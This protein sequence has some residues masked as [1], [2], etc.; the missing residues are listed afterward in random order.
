MINPK[1]QDHR[2]KQDKQAK[3]DREKREKQDAEKLDELYASFEKEFLGESKE[4]ERNAKASQ[5]AEAN[6]PEA[7]KKRNLDDLVASFENGD[8]IINNEPQEV[9]EPRAKRKSKSKLDALVAQFKQGEGDDPKEDEQNES[10][11]ALLLPPGTIEGMVEQTQKQIAAMMQAREEEM[12]QKKMDAAREKQ[13]AKPKPFSSVGPRI[14]APKT[15]VA[16]P[17]IPGFGEFKDS[18]LEKQKIPGKFREPL[19]APPRVPQ[20][21]GNFQSAANEPPFTKAVSLAGM[22]LAGMVEGSVIDHEALPIPAPPPPQPSGLSDDMMAGASRQM[23]EN[24]LKKISG[25]PEQQA[26]AELLERLIADKVKEE[27]QKEEAEKLGGLP[28]LPAISPHL[29]AEVFRGTPEPAIP[30]LNLPI[31]LPA[32]RKTPAEIIAEVEKRMQSVSD[33]S[34]VGLHQATSSVH[35][36]GQAA[37]MSNVPRRKTPAEIVAEAEA[38]LQGI[39]VASFSQVFSPDTQQLSHS[40]QSSGSQEFSLARYAQAERQ[41]DIVNKRPL[42]ELASKWTSKKQKWN[43]WD[44]NDESDEEP[45]QA[46]QEPSQSSKWTSSKWNDSESDKKVEKKG[47]TPQQGLEIW[48]GDWTCPMCQVLVFGWKDECG[49]CKVPKDLGVAPEV[50]FITKGL[51][52]PEMKQAP[53]DPLEGLTMQERME[54]LIRNLGN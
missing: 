25:N 20:D 26:E 15:F 54:A 46:W 21:D 29:M 9:E 40:A 52:A 41:A 10:A 2:W 24:I 4:D 6:K 13:Q 49:L 39:S 32:R 14:S 47:W 28:G 8:N 7:K 23:M 27:E 31:N 42:S 16:P 50:A 5:E 30:K 43:R 36:M 53:I 33:S 38:G 45:T 51:E 44:D 35:D 22:S 17:K 1:L 11:S 37:I 3:R 48:E 18:R 19:A 34:E 12:L